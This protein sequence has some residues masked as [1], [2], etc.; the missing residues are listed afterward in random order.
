ML[1]KINPFLTLLLIVAILS[2]CQTT[3]KDTRLDKASRENKN[4]WI[5][6][7]LEGSPATIGYQHGFLLANDI[8]TSVQA[9][10]HLLTHETK[11]D[12]NFYRD[13]ARNFL[14]NKLD[15]E[16]KDEI[17]GI[18]EGL[19]AK[20]LNYDSLDITAYNALEELA[21]YYV[22]QV[23]EKEKAGTGLNKAPGNCS[24][25]IATG[26]YTSDGKIVI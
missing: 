6:V 25:F 4:G 19:Q 8:D 26:S 23:Q 24:A 2:G 17:N 21:Y 18:V 16:Y 1:S 13:A 10:K 9:V 22:P 11:K 7:H 3:Q 12:W 20:H 5:Y 15:R 14:W